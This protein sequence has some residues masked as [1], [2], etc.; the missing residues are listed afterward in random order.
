MAL[1]RE[2]NN[3]GYDQFFVNSSRKY[4]PKIVNA[5]QR[6]GCDAVAAITADAIG[7]RGKSRDQVLETC[8]QKFYKLTEIEPKLFAFVDEFQD[9]IVLERTYVA[10]P[11]PTRGYTSVSAVKARLEF[12]KATDF[13][14]DALRQLAAQL[15]A[16]NEISASDAELEGA[17]CLFLFSRHLRAGNLDA[18]ETLAPR[19][20]E[21]AREDTTQLV[22]HKEWVAKLIEASRAELADQWSIRYLEYLHGDD[23]SS[24][25]IQKRGTNGLAYNWVNPVDLGPPG[26]TDYVAIFQLQNGRE[27][28]FDS[29]EINLRRVFEKGHVI[30]GSYIRSKTRSSQVLDFNV[31]NPIFSTQLPGPYSWDTPNRFLSWG[32]LPLIKGFDLGYSTE[33]RTGFPFYLVDNQRQLAALPGNEMIPSFLRFPA[34]FTLNTHLEKRFHA[35]GFYWAIRGGFDNVTSHKNYGSVN[36]DVDSPQF[37]TFSGFSGRSFTGRT[38]RRRRISST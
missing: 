14:F 21:L 17:T 4:A 13:S 30:M 10:P 11:P 32:F 5:L 12:A 26:V 18:C 6:I 19:V 31:D 35:F 27:D 34:Y 24:E 2:V 7:A 3:G 29:F 28:R 8:D 1:Q 9:R 36:N 38:P 16:E 23:T 25:F 33:F 15:A 20:F 37:L 22:L